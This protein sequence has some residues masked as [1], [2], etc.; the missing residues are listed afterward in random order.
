MSSTQPDVADVCHGV[1]L[2]CFVPIISFVRHVSC[3]VAVLLASTIEEVDNEGTCCTGE[4]IPALP[5]PGVPRGHRPTRVVV[6]VS[7]QGWR[8]V[9]TGWPRMRRQGSRRRWAANRR[10]VQQNEA[11]SSKHNAIKTALERAT[12]WMQ[13]C[14]LFSKIV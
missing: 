5:I 3:H 14:Q 13:L 12:V 1:S 7:L 9:T 6:F 11:Q 10:P 4:Q 8:Y 2:S